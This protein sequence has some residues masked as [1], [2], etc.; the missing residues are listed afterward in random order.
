MSPWT[1]VLILVLAGD[2]VSLEIEPHEELEDSVAEMTAKMDLMNFRFQ[3][4]PPIWINFYCRRRPE[5]V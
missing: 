1:C 3:M 2:W 5:S 4:D